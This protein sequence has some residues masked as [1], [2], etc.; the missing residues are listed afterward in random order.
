MA[1]D[2]LFREPNFAESAMSFIQDL[3]HFGS[4]QQAQHRLNATEHE[5]F[6]GT[7]YFRP[8][9]VARMLDLPFSRG[10]LKSTL[11]ELVQRKREGTKEMRFVLCMI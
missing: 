8:E 10:T 7:S 6:L 9:I 11:Q 4:D 3:H 5:F 1:L 2:Y